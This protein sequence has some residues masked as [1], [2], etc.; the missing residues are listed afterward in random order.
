M[1]LTPRPC[2]GCKTLVEPSGVGS[3]G[4][5]LV[6]ES[7]MKPN[8]LIISPP[9]CWDCRG[10][11][12]LDTPPAEE[13]LLPAPGILGEM[14]FRCDRPPAPGAIPIFRFVCG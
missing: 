9:L 5:T 4:Q 7:R 10:A 11:V 14:G 3:Y 2:F 13:F 12:L 6:H 8:E 1:Q